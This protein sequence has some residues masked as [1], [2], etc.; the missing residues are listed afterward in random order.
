VWK[1]RFKRVAYWTDEPPAGQDDA[2]P[3]TALNKVYPMGLENLKKIIEE[4]Q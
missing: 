3:L 2:T 4:N 1:A